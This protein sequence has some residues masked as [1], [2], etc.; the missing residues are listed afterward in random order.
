[1]SSYVGGTVSSLIQL[2]MRNKAFYESYRSGQIDLET[3][4]QKLLKE[5][6]AILDEGYVSEHE[7]HLTLQSPVDETLFVETALNSLRNAGAIADAGYDTA[8]F[9]R[10]RARMEC[11]YS[12]AGNETFI[13]PEEERLAFALT[14]IFK[15]KRIFFLGSFYG[16]WAMWALSAL[17]GPDSLV[18]LVD[19]DE[20]VQAVAHDNAERFGFRG[21]VRVVNADVEEFLA[22]SNEAFDMAFLDA[23]GPFDAADPD[24]RGKS[25][26]YPHIRALFPRLKPSSVVVCHNI[27]LTAQVKDSVLTRE[28]SE[29]KAALEK[30]LNFIAS[31]FRIE[32][33]IPSTKGIGVYVV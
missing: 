30:F 28:I 6:Y 23:D 29:H 20:D 26:Y 1:M 22:S 32:R 7:L 27:F 15:P 5:K 31:N 19:I 16:Y 3:Y 14:N 21:H 8:A 17:G 4:Y 12:H 13:F 9:D 2:A 10:F 25:I 24:Y 33:T 18:Y 11:D